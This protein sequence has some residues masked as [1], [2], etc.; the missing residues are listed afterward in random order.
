[1]NTT[2][3]AVKNI[4]RSR[5][6]TRAFRDASTDA[7]FRVTQ[8]YWWTDGLYVVVTPKTCENREEA[9]NQA[10]DE[11]RM[12]I[13]SFNAHFEGKDK[14]FMEDLFHEILE[15]RKS[16]TTQNNHSGSGSLKG[17]LRLW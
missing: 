16:N 14:K 8:K 13:S 1:M 2:P 3:T 10:S 7:R 17:R 6:K 15:R 4:A 11:A 9:K 5:S 12:L